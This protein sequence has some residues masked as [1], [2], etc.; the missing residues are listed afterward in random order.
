M[1]SFRSNGYSSGSPLRVRTIDDCVTDSSPPLTLHPLDGVGEHDE[2][3]LST[4][5]DIEAL[6]SSLNNE[7]NHLPQ[8]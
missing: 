8:W 7:D 5:E 4:G 1:L 2:A 6:A 3:V